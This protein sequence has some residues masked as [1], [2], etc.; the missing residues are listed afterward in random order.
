MTTTLLALLLA[1]SP[2]TTPVPSAAS[3]AP[4]KPWFRDVTATHLPERASVARNTMDVAAVDLD[5]D[6]DLDVV[7][8]Q[9]FL[10][11][12]IL[13]NGGDGHFTDGSSLLP[14][15]S[16]DELKGA[17]TTGHDTEDVS[18]ADFDRDGRP[19]LLFVSEDDVKFPRSPVHEYY[20][21]DEKGGFVRIL[22]QLPDTEANAVSHADLTGDGTLDVLISGFG[23][24]VLLVGDGKGGFRDETA[25]RLPRDTSLAQDALLLDVDK[26]GD[27]D[28][29]LGLEGG[30]AL[31]I[32]DGKGKFRDESD[33]RLPRFSRVSDHQSGD[34]E[35]RK[36]VAG[37]VDR[38][39]DPDLYIAHVGWQGRAPQDRLLLNDGRGRFTDG[40][41]G[42]LPDDVDTTLDAQ[43]ADLDG[44]G[45][46]D[47]VRSGLNMLQLLENDG[48]GR[49]T[50]VSAT[51][52]PAGIEPGIAIAIELADFDGDGKL[53]LYV[54][55]LATQQNAPGGY[56]RLLLGI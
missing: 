28:V 20:R 16:P 10:P 36:I 4:A 37:D 40:T 8:A 49:F 41:A 47:L 17:A 6:G 51:R 3:P 46:L 1:A 24:D 12:K 23:Q 25:A 11:N 32:N 13:L 7:T 39:G 44:D 33:P 45:D 15:L 22:G 43:F 48:R 5:A 2:A 53:D 18:V 14:A 50:E 56:D 9:E 35:A 31:W 29:V 55:M 30:H 19:D 52:L 34:V 26:D 21:R 42:R 38:D 54:G 27:L